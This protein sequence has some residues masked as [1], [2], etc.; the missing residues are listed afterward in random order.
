MT[1]TNRHILALSSGA[2]GAYI[3]NEKSNIHPVLMGA[4]LSLLLSKVLLGDYDKGYQ[5]S[6]S[7]IW[8]ALQ[9]VLEGGLGAW[10]ATVV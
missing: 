5:W 9:A 3:P 4:L 10:I 8:F 6:V 2:I 1:S 7:D